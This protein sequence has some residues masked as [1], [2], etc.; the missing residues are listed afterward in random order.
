MFSR[1][2]IYGVLVKESC[3]CRVFEFF[4]MVT[5][6]NK[7]A[8]GYKFRCTTSSLI[9]ESLLK[10]SSL[11][12]ICLPLCIK[13]DILPNFF[14]LFLSVT[15]FLGLSCYIY[16]RLLSPD[17]KL[18]SCLLFWVFIKTRTVLLLLDAE[19]IAWHYYRFIWPRYRSIGKKI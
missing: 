6:L 12:R 5:G 7:C 17:L 3:S 11:I 4:R 14:Q 10:I 8:Y 9:F 13:F 16:L 18:S 2:V 1:L 15:T 19:S